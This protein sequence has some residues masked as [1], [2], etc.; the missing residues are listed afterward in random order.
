M[1]FD[2]SL[3]AKKEIAETSIKEEKED[4]CTT[5]M[6]K[7]RCRRKIFQSIKGCNAP[8]PYSLGATNIGS[9]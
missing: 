8:P 2:I 5:S 3:S 4:V 1:G 9:A 7:K 6:D